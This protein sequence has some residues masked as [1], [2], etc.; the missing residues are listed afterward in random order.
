MLH[1]QTLCS[2][3]HI[4]VRSVESFFLFFCTDLLNRTAT[5]PPTYLQVF[6]AALVRHRFRLPPPCPGESWLQLHDFREAV[7]AGAERRVRPFPG[8]GSPKAEASK[9]SGGSSGRSSPTAFI[10]GTG[11]AAGQH[12]G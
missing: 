2:G 6:G 9:G 8:Q 7:R 10:G 11:A 3:C 4:R 5:R 12:G 1:V